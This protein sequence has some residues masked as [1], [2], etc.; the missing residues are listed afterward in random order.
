MEKYKLILKNADKS[1][2]VRRT[3]EAKSR[4]ALV[5]Q[6]EAIA[7]KE[8]LF[9]VRAYLL[10]KSKRVKKFKFET[11]SKGKLTISKPMDIRKINITKKPATKTLSPAA[12]KKAK[13]VAAKKKA[14]A[15]AKKHAKA[16]AELNTN[17]KP[18]AQK[19]TSQPAPAKKEEPAQ[20]APS[21]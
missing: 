11:S 10:E 17:K 1:V 12:I 13:E 18:T 7:K 5:A 16:L 20:P 15:E 3:V 2:K 4:K 9:I 19:A 14:K 21:K 6:I 8:E